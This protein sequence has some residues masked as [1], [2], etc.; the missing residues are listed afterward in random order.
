MTRI[1]GAPLS[2]E[3]RAA[4]LVEA[5]KLLDTPW[6]HQGRTSRGVDCLGFVWLAMSRALQQTR[7][8]IQKPRSDYG[9]LPYDGQLREGLIEWMGDPVK[10][11]APGD[12]AVF[13]WTGDPHHVAFVT[14]HSFHGLG[15]IHAD[16]T[17]TGG[18]RVVEHGWDHVWDRRLIE[19]F[20][21]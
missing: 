8:E 2:V 7:G 3:E 17:A 20:R 15:L 13:R 6:R 4:V 5:R 10:R 19:G 12:I 18:G 16:N 21:P 1:L 9:R 11:P 14:E